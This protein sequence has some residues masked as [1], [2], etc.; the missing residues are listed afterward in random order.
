[1]IRGMEVGGRSGERYAEVRGL[2][3]VRVPACGAYTV[4]AALGQGVCGGGVPELREAVEG[5]D[6]VEA[7][8]GLREREGEGAADGRRGAADGVP[9]VRGEV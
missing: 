8:R 2:S 7:V 9:G 5:G 4:D 1:M 6:A 3:E